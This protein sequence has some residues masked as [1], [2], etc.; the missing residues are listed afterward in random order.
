MPTLLDLY[1]QAGEG[2]RESNLARLKETRGIYEDI[3]GM[4]APGGAFGRGYE[5]MLERTK[6]RDVASGA[7][8]L[9]GSGLYNTTQTAGLGKA[10]EEDVGM[11]SRMRLE[12][13]RME[14]YAG[15]KRDIAG[16]LERVEEPYP[17]YSGLM[18]ASAA[19]AAG[20]SSIGSA[21]SRWATHPILGG[22][23][24]RSRSQ[25]LGHATI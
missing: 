22:A 24:R 3:A 14:K 16:L 17:D 10:W 9:V 4:F 13:V 1:K 20:G 23:A 8:A 19:Q 7:Q 21:A 15:A 2:A 5:A 18:Q 25:F 11:P 12:D 6:K